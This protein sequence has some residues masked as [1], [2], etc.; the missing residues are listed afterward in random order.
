MECPAKSLEECLTYL[1]LPK[2]HRRR[3]QTTNR[4]E[5]LFE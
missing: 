3:V 1:K 4:L 2:S 5:R